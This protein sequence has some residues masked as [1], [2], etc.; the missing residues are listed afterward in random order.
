MPKSREGKHDDHPLREPCTARCW[1][2][3]YDVGESPCPGCRLPVL[4]HF[5]SGKLIRTEACDRCGAGEQRGHF[6]HLAG[7]ACTAPCLVDDLRLVRCLRCANEYE[8]RFVN[9]TP[10]HGCVRCELKL[11]PAAERCMACNAAGARMCNQCLDRAQRRVCILCGRAPINRQRGYAEGDLPDWGWCG[12]CH[13]K[14]P[15]SLGDD[16]NRE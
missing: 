8:V 4:A 6:G 11:S 5:K 13:K 15:D 9:G 16:V 1:E 14:T 10:K 7:E 2:I 3:I 12:E